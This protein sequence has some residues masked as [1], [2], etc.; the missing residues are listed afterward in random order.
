MTTMKAVRIHEYGG[1]DVLKC[2]EAPYPVV[3]HG[4]V[5]VRVKAA[6]VNPI[7]W[8]VR[9]GMRRKVLPHVLPMIPGWDLSG[10]V[11][12]VGPG[13]NAFAPGD[14]VF[15]RSDL[16]RDGSYAELI[17]VRAR[18][19]TAK[20]LSLD[21]VQAAAVPLAALTAWQVLFGAP[22][23]HSSIN[24]QKGQTILIHGAA[25]GV[26]TFAVQLAKWRGVTVFATASAS[27]VEFLRGLG[28][29]EVIDYTRQPFE[30]VVRDVDAVFDTIG[31]ETQAR[32]WKVLRRNG[33]L[34][35]IVSRPSDDEGKARGVRSAHV[36]L[37]PV[38]EQ[39]TEIAGLV[40]SGTVKPIVTHVLPLEEA[41]RAQE[42]SQ[43]GHVRGKIV[44]DIAT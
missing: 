13:V 18:E 15:G 19:V 36:V 24:L 30:E 32:S 11:E 22:D 9:Q 35:S 12:C 5:L 14:E 23:A 2:E 17:A 39:L 10:V 29:D 26:G 6:A 34:A 40:D 37:E 7:D 43:A 44:L 8:K 31:G 25:G 21:H 33:V 28:A 41:P 16:I 1:P 3:G 20:P 42:L 38:L 4:D 27:N